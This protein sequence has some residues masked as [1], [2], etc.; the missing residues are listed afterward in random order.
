LVKRLLKP[1]KKKKSETVAKRSKLEEG[2]THAR[3]GAS[4]LHNE[5]DLK[6]KKTTKGWRGKE[7]EERMKENESLHLAIGGGCL[8]VKAGEVAKGTV[9]D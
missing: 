3:K 8:P 7:K 5:G 9:F 1:L 2:G 4:L 6:R